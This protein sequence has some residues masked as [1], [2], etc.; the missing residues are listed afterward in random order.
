MKPMTSPPAFELRASY[1]G[2]D[3]TGASL[4]RSRHHVLARG[5]WFKAIAAAR[6]SGLLTATTALGALAILAAAAIANAAGAPPPPPPQTGTCHDLEVTIPGRVEAIQRWKA[7]YD[8]FT[9]EQKASDP[10]AIA[11]LKYIKNYQQET[12]ALQAKYRSLGCDKR[13]H[14]PTGTITLVVTWSP[15]PHQ[16]GMPDHQHTLDAQCTAL[17]QF[18]A[19]GT[20]H[21]T[22]DFSWTENTVETD[23]NGTRTETVLTKQGKYD[24]TI[25]DAAKINFVGG[26]EIVYDYFVNYQ[27][28][29]PSMRISG[30]MVT[31]STSQEINEVSSCWSLMG[32][33]APTP[34]G[35]KNPSKPKLVSDPHG[36]SEE[37][38]RSPELHLKAEIS[39][40]LAAP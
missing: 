20:A 34:H 9:P 40:Q 31:Q 16:G 10:K 4:T 2:L 23:S 22:Q 5:S 30:T 24:D 39:W 12:N 11:F 28:P 1:A 37:G 14:N 19:D 21:L 3:G 8:D 15:G 7:Q 35:F 32:K 36:L 27:T 33:P 25:A 13:S 26:P 29:Q 17:L 18:H 6:E 38:D